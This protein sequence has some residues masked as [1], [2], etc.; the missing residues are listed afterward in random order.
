MRHFFANLV[1][2]FFISKKSRRRIR[3]KIMKKSPI[4]QP[5]LNNNIDELEIKQKQLFQIES[6]INEKLQELDNLEKKYNYQCL[7]SEWLMHNNGKILLPGRFKEYDLIFAIGATCISTDMIKSFGLRR[8]ANPF[9]WTAGTEPKHWLQQPNIYRDSRFREKIS[10]ICDNFHDWLTPEYFKYVSIW[11]NP[12]DLNHHVV[13]IKTNIRYLHEFPADQDIMQYMPEFI[14]KMRRRI[15]NLYDAIDKSQ[16]I[17]VVWAANAYNDQ[18]ALLEQPVPDKDIKWAV[19]QMQKIYPDKKFDFVFFEQDGSKEKFEYEKIEVAPG[20]FKIKS[21]HF[22]IDCEYNFVA[23]APEYRPHT[24]VISEM[25]DNIHL[26][27]NAFKLTGSRK[28]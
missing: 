27:K 3:N 19:K 9:D 26:S 1:A 18:L 5:K 22:L 11:H 6:Q 13:N 24:H 4:I 8:F 16:K 28:I 17:L 21:N 7:K 23:Q 10:A 20:A 15:N 2:M 12:K 25:L 14:K